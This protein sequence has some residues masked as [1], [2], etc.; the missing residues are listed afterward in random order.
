LIAWPWKRGWLFY[1]YFCTKIETFRKHQ[2][3]R[4]RITLRETKKT[5]NYSKKYFETLFYYNIIVKVFPLP[6]LYFEASK[7]PLKYFQQREA[8][9]QTFFIKKK[10]LWHFGNTNF[11]HELFRWPS[12]VI[13]SP[14][15]SSTS[16]GFVICKNKAAKIGIPQKLALVSNNYDYWYSYYLFSAF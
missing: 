7:P 2:L 14:E 4:T 15:F 11:D 8:I 9:K 3:F 16:I 10:L 6:T 1:H 5:G 12:D 13:S